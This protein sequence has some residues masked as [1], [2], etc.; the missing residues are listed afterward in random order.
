MKRL[1]DI[2][3]LSGVAVKMNADLLRQ[4]EGVQ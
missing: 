2:S 1:N 3:R 4:V